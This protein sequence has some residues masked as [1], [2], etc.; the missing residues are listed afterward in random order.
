[1]A[2]DLLNDIGKEGVM[3]DIDSGAIGWSPS[4][5]NVSGASF[6][7]PVGAAAHHDQ[8]TRSI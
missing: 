6:S 2:A 5:Q 7:T 8:C 3:A 1:M 4:L